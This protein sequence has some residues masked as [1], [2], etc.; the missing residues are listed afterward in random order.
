MKAK[1][2]AAI[3]LLVI[4][5]AAVASEAALATSVP[6]DT[7]TYDYW[8][9]IVYTPAAYIPG[10]SISGVSLGTGTFN[11]PQGIF[12]APDGAVY[13]A[14]T[15]N[16]RIVVLEPDLHTVR[17]VIST[18]DNNGTE[19]SFNR[20]R[21]VT[22]SPDGLIYI[23]D[24]ENRRVVALDGTTL[25]KTI[26]DPE[27][28]LLGENFDFVPLKVAVDFAG[29]VFVIARNMFQ[30]IMT[31][32]QDGEFVGFY[33]TINVNIT[34]WQRFWRALSTQEQR[35]R[36][37]QFIPTEFTG[38]DVDP[39]GF[40]FASNIDMAG[41]Q[42]VRR[43]NP[44]G[45]DVIRRGEN[46]HLGGDLL[47]FPFSDSPYSGPSNIIDVA[48]RGKGM[49]SL[50]DSRR[51][52]IFTYDREGNLLYVFGGMGQQAGTFR[53]PTAIA[54]QEGRILALDAIRNELII[55]EQTL[56]G[57]LINRAV[58]L[59]Y[60]GDEALAVETWREV[61][62]LN[63]NLELANAGIGKAYLTAG[64]NI[65]AMR[66]LE[67]GMDR[68]HYSIAFRRYRNDILKDNIGWM[69]TVMVAG[70]FGFVVLRAL[71]RRRHKD[72]IDDGGGTMDA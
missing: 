41:E 25:V 40:I 5:V 61:L 37:Q 35:A 31:F 24:T 13:I 67:L 65:N 48:Y 50:L 53:Q 4:I 46:E 58:S 18:F 63:E 69:L 29:R 38:L 32:N 52:R 45:E 70:I 54:V 51:G 59:R 30:G 39:M 55:F 36:Q 6:Y 7:Y 34:L 23:A 15:G 44:N 9:F 3:I 66:Y 27:A 47:M 8:G 57:E 71:R 62:I 10:E 56:Y 22:V 1:R 68:H 20:P 16:N 42:A 2:I 19:D 12:A 49:Y 33:G 72:V 11:D 43:L 14:D 60:D 26:R 28:E 21:G 17:D 64:D